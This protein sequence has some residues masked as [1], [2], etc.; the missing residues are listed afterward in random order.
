MCMYTEKNMPTTELE[1]LFFVCFYQVKFYSQLHNLSEVLFQFLRFVFWQGSIFPLLHNSSATNVSTAADIWRDREDGR[2]I[3]PNH[4]NWTQG[5]VID[6][7]TLVVT[8]KVA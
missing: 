7:H 3:G 1:I 6:Q 4:G 8:W 2:L 5:G